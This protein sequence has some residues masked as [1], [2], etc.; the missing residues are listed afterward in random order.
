VTNLPVEIN[1]KML[2]VLFKQYPGYVQSKCFD[3]KHIAFIE[4][5]TE[6]Q[7]G[8]ALTGLNGFKITPTNSINVT[9]APK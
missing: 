4:F 1:Q 2:E 8:V 6:E 9:Y 5:D 3:D 7:A